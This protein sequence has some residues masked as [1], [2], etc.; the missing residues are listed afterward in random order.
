M[1][2]ARPLLLSLLL[3]I[4][5]FPPPR[6]DATTAV[7]SKGQRPKVVAGGFVQCVPAEPVITTAMHENGLAVAAQLKV[8]MTP[9]EVEPLLGKFDRFAWP[10]INLVREKCQHGPCS[11]EVEV[12]VGAVNVRFAAGEDRIVRAKSVQVLPA[13][14]NVKP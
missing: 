9:E 8:G 12:R 3:A 6:A 2:P 1:H 13:N 4:A 14:P 5:A 11:M 7:P 10:L